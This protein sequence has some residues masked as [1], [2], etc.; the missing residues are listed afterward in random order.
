MEHDKFYVNSILWS[1]NVWI[2]TTK[3]TYPVHHHLYQIFVSFAI[4]KYPEIHLDWNQIYQMFLWLQL[5]SFF[6][7]LLHVSSFLLLLFFCI[8]RA[9]LFHYLPQL[10]SVPPSRFEF[11]QHHLL[12]LKAPLLW[13]FSLFLI[14]PLKK[15]KQFFTKK[16]FDM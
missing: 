10:S 3:S 8:L 5:D 12:F 15:I 1:I 9:Q 13:L 14:V 11:C 4:L 7:L 16:Y 2:L 6:L